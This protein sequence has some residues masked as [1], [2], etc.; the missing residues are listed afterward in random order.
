MSQHEDNQSAKYAF[1]P[2]PS[3][4]QSP[5]ALIGSTAQQNLSTLKPRL[6][7][8]VLVALTAAVSAPLGFV[9]GT[10]VGGNETP[11]AEME[12]TDE[13]DSFGETPVVTPAPS[14]KKTS[15]AKIDA[16]K[17]FFPKAKKATLRFTS[18]GKL[19]RTQVV[20]RL[21][22]G[23]DWRVK[24]STI[25]AGEK[26]PRTVW[27]YA[28]K[29]NNIVVVE[30][31][32]MGATSEKGLSEKFAPAMVGVGDVLPLGPYRIVQTDATVTTA[33]GKLNNCLVGESKAQAEGSEP[34]RVYWCKDIG[35]VRDK[36]IHEDLVLQR[37]EPASAFP[38]VVQTAEANANGEATS[39]KD[40]ALAA[41]VTAK[42]SKAKAGKD[43]AM[44]G[45]AAKDPAAV[46][47]EAKAEAKKKGKKTKA[48]KPPAAAKPAP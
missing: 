44:H 33:Q 42:D 32:A 20:E 11:L 2:E 12:P 29:A 9:A 39:A 7:V 48:K 13:V 15:T 27:T 41:P 37:V 18:G 22:E 24:V 14:T 4:R 45:M 43:S 46:S 35:M 26:E 47:P 36:S 19:V 40:G 25:E 21:G 3:L 38:G 17:V 16:S 30:R 23:N 28:I 10:F 31:W 34:S 8:S 5:S 1:A 6:P